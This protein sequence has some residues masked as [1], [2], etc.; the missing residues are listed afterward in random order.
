MKRKYVIL[1]IVNIFLILIVSSIFAFVINAYSDSNEDDNRSDTNNEREIV[2]DYSGTITPENKSVEYLIIIAIPV[3]LRNGS[4]IVHP[5]F[6]EALDLDG[7][8]SEYGISENEYGLGLYFNARGDMF[9]SLRNAKKNV[10][11][12]SLDMSYRIEDPSSELKGRDKNYYCFLS[13]NT[14]VS[15]QLLCSITHI[16]GWDYYRQTSVMR[17]DLEPG[18]NEVEGYFSEIMS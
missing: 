7:N 5:D 1:L 3:V 16:G 8:I 15:I 18:Y 11:Y 14:I 9:I 13:S 6:M 10:T 12:G 17:G 4:Y 2:Y